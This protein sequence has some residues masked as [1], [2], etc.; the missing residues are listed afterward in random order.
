MPSL[1]RFAREL[2]GRLW[3][4]PVDREV[5]AEVAYHL[6]MRIAEYVAAG[7]EPAAAR[8][9]A[10][11]RFGDVA[12]ITADCR[13]LGRERDRRMRITDWLAELR[14]DGRYAVRHLR[15]NPA[16]AVVASLTI[17]L[18]IGTSTTIFGIANAILLRPL[19]FPA[20]E[21]LVRIWEANPRDDRFGVSEPNF[22]D[23]RDRSR[24]FGTLAAYA[25]RSVSIFGDGE[26]ERLAG[27]A[28]T[29]AFF[30]VLGVAPLLGR[31]F[32][33]EETQP[34][35]APPVAVLAHRLWQTRFGGDA[36]VLGRT[37][38][39]DGVPYTIIGVMPP[40]FDF[41]SN[42]DV[43]LP[44]APSPTSVRADHRLRVIGRLASGATLDRATTELRGVAR[45]LG[46]AYPKSNGE[47]SVT[48]LSFDD[49]IVGREL[50]TRVLVLLAAVGLLLLM[51]CVNVASLLLA[52]AT[53]R[54]RD[55]VVRA[56]LGAGR[57]R[58]VRQALTESLVLSLAGAA[59]GIAL[60]YVAVP[61]LRATAADAVPRLDEMTVDARVLVFGAAASVITGLLFGLMPALQG[62]R[63]RI[64]SALRG[65][66]RV[67]PGG[68]RGVLT[69]ASVAL[70]MLLLVGAGLIGA[71][72]VRLMA[73]DPGFRTE[74]VLVASITLPRSRYPDDARRAAFYREVT[75][76]LAAL[77]GVRAVGTTNVIPFGGGGTSTQ[78]TPLDRVDEPA[79]YHEA[80]WRSVTPGYFAALGV[81]LKRGRLIDASDA[82]AAQRVLVVSERLA[83]RVWPGK[84][85]IGQQVRVMGQHAPWTVVGVVSDIRDQ[86]L[87]GDPRE[88]MYLSYE[89]VPWPAAWLL[90]RTSGDP[91]ALAG[92]L[93]RTTWSIDGALPVSEVQPLARRVSDASA[94]PRLTLLVFLLFAGT[95]LT[96]A[97]VG[98]YGVVAYGVAQQTREIGVRLALGAKRSAI[99][100][101]VVGRGMRLAV[102]GIALG[103]GAALVLSRFVVSILFG[104]AATDA[105]TY[106]AVALLLGAAAAA[107]SAIPAGTAARLDPVKALRDERT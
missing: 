8:A 92:A 20:P 28:V 18:G 77:P 95:A 101:S 64:A 10:L 12:R 57:G 94:Q 6:D 43:W 72:F 85:A 69:V 73:V 47:W 5:D 22:L 106:V 11:R 71:S 9:A 50:R 24:A 35:A 88:T 65:G 75:R 68:A 29:S 93:R 4:P 97:A 54:Q 40:T 67:A 2:R 21:R 100:A 96:L 30:R 19:P 53:A 26:P 81:T 42:I 51:A 74:D 49:W 45:D 55:F 79:G 56:A 1:G 17:A 59:I 90:V 84:D 25:G 33:D 80:D 58:I 46:R 3:K 104:V 66:T 76:R 103:V 78:F 91:M 98:I 32:T 48:L 82:D 13:T 52:R 31:T 99:V 86:T 63:A 41:P 23:W 36:R 27:S 102:V 7:M 44:L 60:T 34:G 14:Q 89:Q 87:D 15:A 39:L 16:F 83:S 61:L 105:T 62:S 38:P 37:V 70:A 107:A